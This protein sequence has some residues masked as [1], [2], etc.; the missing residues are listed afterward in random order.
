MARGKPKDNAGGFTTF[1]VHYEDGTITSNRRIANDRLDQSFG[2]T[3][4]DLARAALKEQ[5]REIAR[6]S[7]R[8]RVKIKK[9]VTS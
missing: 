4:P 3:L 2:D 9:T 8:R 6:L 5:D 7:N 1:I